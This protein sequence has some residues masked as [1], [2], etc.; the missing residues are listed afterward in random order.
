MLTPIVSVLLV[1]QQ[2][3]PILSKIDFKYPG[4]F[5]N[6]EGTHLFATLHIS[7]INLRTGQL[8]YD[9]WFRAGIH[10]GN[11]P[12]AVSRTKNQ[13]HY[14]TDDPFFGP[15]V[16]TGDYD[17]RE[18]DILDAIGEKRILALGNTRSSER[19]PKYVVMTEVKTEFRTGN[20]NHSWL[21]T[22]PEQYRVYPASA[23]FVDDKTVELWV[24]FK[25]GNNFSLDRYFGSREGSSQILKRV[26]SVPIKNFP[27]ERRAVLIN[28]WNPVEKTFISS[29]R[30][31]NQYVL[32]N[33]QGVALK[34][35]E[36]PKTGRPS[37]GS[38]DGV[39]TGV[40]WELTIANNMVPGG[41]KNW[42][43]FA[44]SANSKIWL[45]KSKS[46]GKFK[47]LKL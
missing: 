19:L 23:R 2:L 33:S 1:G 15:Q 21:L 9:G 14:D 42:I 35:F 44:R 4:G 16:M 22:C 36:L 26:T 37:G 10:K 18:C 30:D 40:V 43:P 17:L 28:T 11:P 5:L 27:F 25:R 7:R 32:Y 13:A 41:K 24:A 31:N 47:L 46:S 8:K 20:P 3:T 38:L 6:G 45:L 12:I 29:G 39:E 34:S